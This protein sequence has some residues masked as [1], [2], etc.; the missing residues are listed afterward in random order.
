[1]ILILVSRVIM[2]R[3]PEALARPPDRPQV[4]AMADQILVGHGPGGASARGRRRGVLPRG[5]PESGSGNEGYEIELAED[6]PEGLRRFT[7]QLPTS[8]S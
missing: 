8:C 7:E 4:T 5:T 1:M 6:G 3:D 2:A